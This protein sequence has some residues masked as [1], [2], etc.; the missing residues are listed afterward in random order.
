MEK[1][2]QL[3][4][5]QN[6]LPKKSGEPVF[7]EVK[8]MEDKEREAAREPEVGARGGNTEKVR[9]MIRNAPPLKPLTRLTKWAARLKNSRYCLIF[10]IR[11]NF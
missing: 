9:M 3:D 10:T 5:S 11:Y 8:H 4:A 2:M 7:A 1:T 6:I